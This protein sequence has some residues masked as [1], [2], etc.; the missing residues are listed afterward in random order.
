MSL[1]SAAG[2]RRTYFVDRRDVVARK[3][4]VGWWV[5]GQWCPT[6]AVR[7]HRIRMLGGRAPAGGG[8]R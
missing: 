4:R 2:T 6:R 8:V 7:D 1:P 5:N 3:A